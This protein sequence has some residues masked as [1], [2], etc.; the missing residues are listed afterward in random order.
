MIICLILS[1]FFSG[2]EVAL[3]SI[4]KKKVQE[5]RK[6]H[7]LMGGYINLLIENPRRLLV[8]ILLGNTIVNIAASITSVLI[9]ID[10]ARI[11]NI[12]KEIA[13]SVQII[14]L[15]I[16][17][18][19]IG[20][21]TPKLWANRYPVQFAKIVSI[22]LYWI[23]VIFFPVAKILTDV[24]RISTSKLKANKLKTALHSTE[25]SELADLSLEKGTIEQ[26]E[27]ELIQGIV[28]FRSVTV[29][30]IMTPRVDIIAVPLN[31][32]FEE[33]MKTITE[34][35]HSRIPLYGKSLDDIQGIIYA[36]DLLPYLKNPELRR[37]LSL[38]KIAREALFVPETKHINDLLHDF[39]EKKL[40]LGIVVDEYG[41][42]AGLISLEDILEEIVGDI[43]DEY[44]KEESQIIKLSENEYLVSGKLSIDELNDLL[45]FNFS[46]EN[47]DYD[48]VGGF[49][50]N[51]AGI[52]PSQGFHFTFNN[53]KFTVKEISNKR[54][55]KVLIEKLSQQEDN[56]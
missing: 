7:G 2:S 10:I 28:S 18:L 33:L 30:E 39:Q 5:I 12:S 35:G 44:D 21:I 8:T 22:P 54:I 47:K 48:T 40:H 50:L 4:D 9:A 56:P 36:K 26:D 6:E 49:I 14:L 53:Y 17:I 19:L 20:E 42:T 41:G 52:I 51:Q 43:R 45:D 11:Y 34:S 13:L 16:V 37:T 23:S 38:K 46:S 27:Q 29:R 31:A 15:T 32:T 25:I 55:R 1:A 3:F 24:L